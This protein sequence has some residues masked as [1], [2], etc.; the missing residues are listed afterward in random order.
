MKSGVNL[1][2]IE[3]TLQEVPSPPHDNG[4][5]MIIIFNYFIPFFGVLSFILIFPSVLKRV[6]EEKA[7]GIKV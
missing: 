7:S 1:S 5:P 6:I 4:D 3:M 2:N